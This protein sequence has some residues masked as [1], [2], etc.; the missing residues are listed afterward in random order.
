L[1][2]VN[3]NNINKNNLTV[4]LN[5]LAFNNFKKCE[6]NN[7]QP[8]FKN[9]TRMIYST[10]IEIIKAESLLVVRNESNQTHQL[11][12]DYLFKSNTS[13]KMPK[14]STVYD[15]FNLSNVNLIILLAL[16]S[17][18]FLIMLILLFKATLIQLITYD[19]L[20]NA[21]EKGIDYLAQSNETIM[22][23]VRYF[24]D[25]SLL[26]DY[27]RNELYKAFKIFKLTTSKKNET[28]N[29]DKNNNNIETLNL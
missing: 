6:T 7:L 5:N 10:I 13:L 22:T 2:K 9:K 1:L 24:S 25:E 17:L 18:S 20:E 19:E 4:Y 16:I 3:T 23:G 15:I 12:N 14:P 27:N 29:T 28:N 11:T 21:D 26:I 8:E